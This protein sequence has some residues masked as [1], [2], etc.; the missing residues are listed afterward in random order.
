VTVLA[1]ELCPGHRLVLNLDES[2][3]IPQLAD[4]Q[5]SVPAA[6]RFPDMVTLT[7][8]RQRI[9]EPIWR[10]PDGSYEPVNP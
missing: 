4:R 3:V 1:C 5:L 8:K 2:V 10:Y 9:K 7:K 6:F